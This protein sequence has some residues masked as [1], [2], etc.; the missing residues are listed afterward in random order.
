MWN[1]D[2]A[3]LALDEAWRALLAK[4]RDLARVWE[5]HGPPPE[6]LRRPGFTGL[7]RAIVGQ[8]ISASAAASI[9]ARLE[10]AV[11]LTPAGLVGAGDRVLR[12]VGLSPQK[13]LY[14]RDLAEAVIEKRLDFRRLERLE[15]EDAIAMLTGVRGIGRW[16][17]EIYLL[18]VM[19]R[20]D[21]LPAADL[22]L[23]EATRHLKRLATRPTEKRFRQLAEPWRPH[24][25]LAAL[26]L[27]HYY[28]HLKQREGV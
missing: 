18:F 15:D 8:Q 17:A 3:R 25:G 1:Q 23:Q 7:L 27:W 20:M 9:W 24:R 16:S 2:K 4:D 6:R 13:M 22:A 28:R 21:A 26:L 19:R 14:V 11:V 10:D 5:R 12:E